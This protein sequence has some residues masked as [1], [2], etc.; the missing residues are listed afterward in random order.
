MIKNPRHERILSVLKQS[1]EVS[2]KELC[3]ILYLSPATVRRDL[4]ALEEKGLLKRNFGGAVLVES[5]SDQLPLSIRSAKNISQKKKLCERAAAYVSDGDTVFIDASS[6]TYFLPYYLKGKQDIT[7]ITNS[8]PLCMLLSEL[9]IRSLCTGGEMLTGSVALAGVDAERFINGIRADAFFFSA[10]GYEPDGG[11]ISD[12][13]KGE[14]DIKSA[15]LKNSKR[16]YF[17]CDLSKLGETHPYKV[18]SACDITAAVT[19]ADEI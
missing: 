11:V 19:E 3:S 1:K 15:M 16:S 7:V 5:F 14:R 4:T 13:S 2:V 17:L 6:T 10:R 12:S 9:R 8:P 18:C